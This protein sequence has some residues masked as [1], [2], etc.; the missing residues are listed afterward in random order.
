MVRRVPFQQKIDSG[1]KFDRAPLVEFLQISGMRIAGLGH[2]EK[3]INQQ[4]PKDDRR[5]LNFTGTSG[6]N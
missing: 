5:S 2:L 6:A 4:K 1:Y 3:R